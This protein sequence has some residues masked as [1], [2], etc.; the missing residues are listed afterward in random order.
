MSLINAI[1][2]ED[3]ELADQ[4]IM[5]RHGLDETDRYGYT[6][7]MLLLQKLQKHK[8][9][10]KLITKLI[11]AG[12]VVNV[13]NI[14]GWTVWNF[15]VYYDHS[16][17]IIRMFIDAGADVNVKKDDTGWTALIYA[18]HQNISLHAIR[19][20]IDTGADVNI[21]NN[22]G[23]TALI[24]VASC[25]NSTYTVRTLIDAGADVNI[26]NNNGHIALSY[27]ARKYRL[28]C[29][30]DAVKMLIEADF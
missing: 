21:K 20:L 2:R 14:Y 24:S 22:N 18:V 17:Y 19:V 9:C 12:A 15:A 4:L 8:V 1:K 23:S 28:Y 10:L 5:D 7:L 13:K 25:S 11:D 26:K 30:I 3:Y 16:M 29:F 27:A 6:S